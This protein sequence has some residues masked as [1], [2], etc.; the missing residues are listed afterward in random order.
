MSAVRHLEVRTNNADEA[1]LTVSQL[2]CNHRLVVRGD[3]GDDVALVLVADE[4]GPMGIVH[5]D[6]G[7]PVDIQPDPLTDFYLIQIPRSGSASIAQD[8]QRVI[9]HASTA[10]V[11]SPTGAVRMSWGAKNPQLCVYLP[12]TVVEGELA[13]LTGDSVGTPLVFDLAMHLR[14]PGGAAFLRS[15]EFLAEELRC[16]S[17]L[18][19]RPER[20][21]PSRSP[22]QVNSCSASPTTT[23][24][25]CELP[26]R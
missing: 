9:S 11:L 7:V 19:Q 13:I 18:I 8:R 2:F 6:Y 25:C 17:S 20:S 15:V 5:L 22:L 24:T 21:S 12:R 4:L 10:S 16:G 1:T 23:A 14:E 3:R 26:S